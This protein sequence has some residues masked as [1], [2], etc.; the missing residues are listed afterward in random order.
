MA[1]A[2]SGPRARECGKQLPEIGRTERKEN[3]GFL[4]P[5]RMGHR[6]PRQSAT[7]PEPGTC[8]SVGRHLQVDCDKPR[9]NEF[10]RCPGAVRH[11]RTNGS[12][13]PYPPA[14]PLS[15]PYRVLPRPVAGVPGWEEMTGCHLPRPT[16]GGEPSHPFRRP[17]R[18]APSDSQHEKTP[19]ADRCPEDRQTRER[20]VQAGSRNGSFSRAFYR[21]RTNSMHALSR[22]GTFCHPQQ[23][24][25]FAPRPG[26]QDHAFAGAEL[27]LPRGQIGRQHHQATH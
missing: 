3:T 6:H 11:R 10:H 20:G 8:Y 14:E 15:V 12:C 25:I 24:H 19:R 18:G 9:Q 22:L 16:R 21:P 27:H 1:G 7:A 2:G 17:T 4:P 26:G 13:R 5:R 23:K